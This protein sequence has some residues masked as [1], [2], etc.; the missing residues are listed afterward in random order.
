M[1][2]GTWHMACQTYALNLFQ[3][4][5]SLN[6]TQFLLSS[7]KSF[8]VAK[9]TPSSRSLLA[10]FSAGTSATSL[11]TSSETALVRS[12]ATC[13]VKLSSISKCLLSSIRPSLVSKLPLWFRLS[14]LSKLSKSALFFALLLLL[15]Y[16]QGSVALTAHT[17]RAI[18]GTAPYLTF[19][20]GQTKATN[21]DTFLA[22]E[23]PDGRRITQSANTSSATNPIRLPSGNFTFN[24]IHTVVP[25]SVPLVNGEYAI[26]INNLVS[27]GKWGDDDGDGQGANGVT[28]SGRIDLTIRD[29]N[30]T[31]VSRN[32][33][34]SLCKA[35]Y[36][37]TLSSTGGAL[38]TRYGVPR[39]SRFYGGTAEYYITLSSQPVICSVRPNLLFGGT[40][41]INSIDNPRFA[42]PSN[43]WSPT[44]G[45]LV[46]SA[47]PSSYELNFPTTGADGLY[48]DLDV[49]GI[50]ASQLSWTVNTS[51]RLRATVSW[52]RPRSGTF[53]AP[54]GR[55]V[56]ADV[57]IRD[58]S[59]YVTRVTLRGPRATS[60]QINSSSPSRLTPSLS[61]PQKFELVGRDSNGN[62]VRYG[63]VL[64]QWFVHRGNKTAS[65]SNQSTWCRDLGYRIV[66]V[67]DLTN[68]VC[69]GYGVNNS[70]PCTGAVGAV[71]SS[72]NNVYMRHI[73]AG[74]FTEWGSMNFY[75]DAGFVANYW[76]SDAAGS[77][78]FSVTSNRGVVLSDSAGYGNY[79]V[80]T[81][82]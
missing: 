11:E 38:E 63:F 23:L 80:C 9:W 30:G 19:D 17:S 47:S 48:F 74:F 73:G 75:A 72:S 69:R 49:G 14:L 21:T 61:L 40:T 8:R 71:P 13:S 34:L 12:S 44:K 42:G 57:W 26:D 2:H 27:Q 5:R 28:A 29:K 58:K 45:F 65:Q 77:G 64:R 56:Q 46:Q 52:T 25:A 79:A 81:A 59:S 70:Y 62:E 4:H 55:T 68:A 51:G 15:S 3:F 76:T 22:I 43:I 78:G 67:R 16:S 60:A 50:D 66:R 35:P 24:D 37:L 7:S 53:T 32:D 6:Q 1:A 39:G 33:T 36:K 41:G 20:G 54:D 82:P 31:T 10:M 18:E